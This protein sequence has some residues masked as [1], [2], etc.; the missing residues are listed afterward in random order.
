MHLECVIV[1]VNYSDFLSQTI[2]HN[3]SHFN[4]MVVVTDLSDIKTKRVCD[5]YN[6]ECIQTN[7]F[8]ENGDTFN[9]AKGIN[10]GM[11][12][13]S[14]TD[15]VLHLDSDIVLPPLFRPILDKLALDK[16]SIYGVDR[17][18][19]HSFEDWQDFLMNPTPMH[20]GWVFVNP[21]IPNFPLGYRISQYFGEGYQPI[22]FFQLWNPKKS[23]I[24]KYPDEHGFADRTDVLFCKLWKPEKR[25]FIPDFCV[26]HLESENSP[27]SRNW[28]GR[29]SK[30]FTYK[31][32]QD[33]L[34]GKESS[35]QY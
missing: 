9:K 2:V 11:E 25:R 4:K 21:G 35:S 7:A 34:S 3:R 14:K 28:Y 20:T 17:Y 27:M 32:K 22:G 33:I 15:W 5:Y 19:C 1:C 18:M 16:S 26:I 6:V 10:A 8:Y 29:K 23:G 12:R 24:D 13:L 31:T 30:V